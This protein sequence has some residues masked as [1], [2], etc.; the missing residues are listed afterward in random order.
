V[1]RAN[2]YPRVA[3]DF[4]LATL[5]LVG[6]FAPWKLV[7]AK[8]QGCSCFYEELVYE[9]ISGLK[10]HCLGFGSIAFRHSL[11]E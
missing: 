1:L 8:N 7:E 5:Q 3:W 11:F 9:N 10:L 6:A 4:F 2:V